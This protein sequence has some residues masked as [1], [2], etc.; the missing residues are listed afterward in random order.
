MKDKTRTYHANLIKKFIEREEEEPTFVASFID[1]EGKQEDP[2]LEE[3]ID[4]LEIS[5]NQE[6]T[7]YDINKELNGEKTE[8]LEEVIRR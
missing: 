1:Y 2:S 6:K 4:E 5:L 8:D 3:I 7:A